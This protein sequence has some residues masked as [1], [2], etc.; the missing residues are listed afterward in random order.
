L[1]MSHAEKVRYRYK[2]DGVDPDWQNVQERHQAFYTNL[3][4]GGYRFH[5]IASNGDGVWNDGGAALDIV[6]PP[7]FWQT[8]TFFGLCIAA[9]LAMIAFLFRLRLR[10]SAA[11]MR[12]LL[13]ERMDERERI[14]REL[15][16]TLL[17]GTQGLMLQVQAAAM[18]IS[19]DDPARVM[20]ERAMGRA[21][22][23]MSEGRNRVLDLRV[24][25][26]SYRSLSQSIEAVV[27]QLRTSANSLDGRAPAYR[28]TIEGDEREVL[29]SVRHEMYCVAREAL[30]NAS[31][32]AAAR[33]VDTRLIFGDRALRVVIA[34][35]GIGIDAGIAEARSRPD[36][37]GL[38][39]M[40][41]RARKVGASFDV[42]RRPSGGTE[43]EIVVPSAV[44]YR[45]Q[46]WTWR[47]FFSAFRRK[48]LLPNRN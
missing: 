17:Q 34:D 36:H 4:P 25:I 1:S 3:S 19:P 11:R 2:L 12:V 40:H 41:E 16:D 29:P 42:R 45:R 24:T 39:G 18:T 46:E 22:D 37:W 27:E 30:L 15:H 26:D 31:R 38:T 33:S 8:K 43:I 35:D 9:I 44:A 47:R 14:A 10:Q 48:R 5:V 7:M 13:N 28:V 21:D 23:V 20:L 6:I 32:H